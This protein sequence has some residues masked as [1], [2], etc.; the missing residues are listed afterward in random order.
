MCK[1]MEVRAPPGNCKSVWG[2]ASQMGRK[3]GREDPRE[4]GKGW[5]VY[6]TFRCLFHSGST[7]QPWNNFKHRSGLQYGKLDPER[8]K[9]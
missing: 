6:V 9:G 5:A 4:A 7:G 3:P 8:H 2:G 1:G